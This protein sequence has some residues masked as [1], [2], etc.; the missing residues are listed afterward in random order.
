[1]ARATK[2]KKPWGSNRA[3]ATD[4][5]VAAESDAIVVGGEIAAAAP[6]IGAA[7]ETVRAALEGFDPSTRKRIVR[8]ANTFLK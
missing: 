1:M 3:A 8:A 6:T 2:K 5:E 4:A 7:I